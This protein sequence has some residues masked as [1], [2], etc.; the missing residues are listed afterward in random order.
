MVRLRT[1]TD[2][3]PWVQLR[4][5]MIN[6][7]ETMTYA[8][9]TMCVFVMLGFQRKLYSLHKPPQD[10][11]KHFFYAYL[12]WGAIITVIAYYGYGFIFSDGISR[13]VII[14]TM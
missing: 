8:V 13:L 7:T 6:A 12:L 10:Y 4:V 11:T 2:L 3:I 9:I 1:M 5:P 14:W